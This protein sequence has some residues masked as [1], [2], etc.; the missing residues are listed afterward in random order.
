MTRRLVG[1][2]FGPQARARYDPVWR[3]ASWDGCRWTSEPVEVPHSTGLILSWNASAPPGAGIAFEVA[4]RVAREWSAWT[5]MGGWGRVPPDTPVDTP[6][7]RDVD[8]ATWDGVADAVMV[9]AHASA[10]GGSRPVLRRVV[11]FCRGRQGTKRVVDPPRSR[12]FVQPVPFRSQMEK[13]PDL[14]ARICGPTSLAMHL[15]AAVPDL[16]TAEVAAASYDPV[17]DLYGNW[18][19]LAAVAGE[20]GFVSWVEQFPSLREVEKRLLAGYGAILSVAFEAGDLDGAPISRTNG[21][22]LVLRGWDGRG[23]SVCN[24]PAFPDE[25]GNGVR[26]RRDQLAC[27]WLRHGGATILLRRD[28]AE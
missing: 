19:R 1:W 6:I 8:T 12:P 21:H 14:G 24:D 27:V 17:H 20:H 5:P 2:T 23:N 28:E 11:A 18:P 22:L 15:A 10:A 4:V 26:Y 9:R 16:A 25:R 13:A 3:D 7:R